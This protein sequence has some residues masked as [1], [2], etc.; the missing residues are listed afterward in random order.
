MSRSGSPPSSWGMS[1]VSAGLSPKKAGASTSGLHLLLVQLQT[2][3]QFQAQAQIHAQV[4]LQVQCRTTRQ[5]WGSDHPPKESLS[6]TGAGTGA[7]YLLSGSPPRSHAIFKRYPH[8]FWEVLNHLESLQ[9]A[10]L[11]LYHCWEVFRQLYQW[12]EHLV[13]QLRGRGGGTSSASS[14]YDWRRRRRGRRP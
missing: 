5:G 1:A 13:G 10:L 11:H 7:H 3:A 8:Y 4:Q 14:L 9:E 6:G 2:W 12:T